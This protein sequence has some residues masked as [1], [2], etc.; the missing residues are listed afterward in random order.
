M[1]MRRAIPSSTPSD[2]GGVTSLKSGA[3]DYGKQEWDAEPIG[4]IE[5][6]AIRRA[7][8]DQIIWGGNYF[9]AHLPNSQCWLVWDKMNGE[10]FSLATLLQMAALPHYAF[11]IVRLRWPIWL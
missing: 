8:N 11:N 5:I 6:E 3:K 10:G 4:P 9:A 2:E 1:T 7:A